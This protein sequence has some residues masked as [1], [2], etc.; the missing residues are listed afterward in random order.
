MPEEERP[1]YGTSE[2][3]N[4]LMQVAGSMK[5][6]STGDK[7]IEHHGIIN[8]YTSDPITEEWFEYEIKFTDGKVADVKRI[9]RE[10]GNG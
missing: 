2:W 1:Y 10:H 8:I 3:K 6:I 4:P 7:I 5:K 9:Y